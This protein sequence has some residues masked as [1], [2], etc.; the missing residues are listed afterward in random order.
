ME[1][2]YYIGD[3]QPGVEALREDSTSIAVHS[4]YT[5]GEPFYIYVTA[6]DGAEQI[7]TIYFVATTIQSNSQPSASD[8]L[9]KHVGGMDFA[10]ATLRKNVSIGVYTSQ[11]NML[12]FSK[13][14][15]SSQ[16]DAVI[17]TNADG[18]DQLLDIYNYT[19]QFTLPEKDQIFFY[20]FFENDEHRIKSGKLKVH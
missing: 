10:V 9:V 17:G 7:Y 1:C 11:G 16:N 15:E 6:Q 13:V 4:Y 8:V 20:V 2:T 3:A 5:A 12:F 18:T 19:T 14:K